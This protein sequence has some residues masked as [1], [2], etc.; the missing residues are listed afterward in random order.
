MLPYKPGEK[1]QRRLTLQTGP[2]CSGANGGPTT[3]S[4]PGPRAFA[5]RTPTLLCPEGPGE[6]LRGSE[7]RCWVHDRE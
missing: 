4:A 6:L 7:S 5:M 1:P 2:R 3:A